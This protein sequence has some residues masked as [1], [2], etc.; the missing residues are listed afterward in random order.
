MGLNVFTELA[1]DEQESMRLLSID[2]L[3]VLAA[4]IKDHDAI[5]THLLPV[6]LDFS[7]D[8][9]V[10]VK[11]ALAIN[12]LQLSEAFGNPIV[13]ETFVDPFVQLAEESDVETRVAIAAQISGFA[14]FLQF[15]TI[16][17]KILP[18]V[19]RIAVDELYIVRCALASSIG[20]LLSTLGDDR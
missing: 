11:R 15:D 10:T 3:I 2:C 6:F 1:Q 18:C 4:L 16:V 17:E 7:V 12:Y 9:S 8:R 13:E 14:K 19:Q 5:V 20:Q